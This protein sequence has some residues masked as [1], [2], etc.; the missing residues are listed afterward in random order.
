MMI[1]K[2]VNYIEIY[3]VFNYEVTCE[4]EAKR[5]NSGT[6]MKTFEES[7]KTATIHRIQQG[8]YGVSA[9]A[10]H[11]NA[12]LSIPYLALIDLILSWTSREINPIRH[13][14]LW[15]IIVNGD[16]QEEPTLTGYQS[17]P[18]APPAPKTT[19]KLVAKRNQERVKSILLLA[20]PDEYLLKF[21]NVPD[22]KSLWEA[23]KSRFGG[24]EESKKMQKNHISQLEVY[25]APVSKEDINKKFLRSL[26]PSWNQI[27][28]I[29][30]NKPD[31]DQTDINDLYNNLRTNEVST[32]N[33]D[34]FI[35]TAGGTS[36]VSSTPC[37]HFQ[38]IDEDGL[39]EL[40]LRWQVAMECKSRRNQGRRSYGDNGRSNAPTNESLLQA[41]MAQ[42]GLGGYDWSNDFEVE[43]VNYALM[44]ISSSTSSSSSDNEV[45]NYSKQCVKSFKT[46]Q[47]N[48]DSERE[49]HN[50]AR[51]EIQGYEIALGSLE[52]RI[53]RHEKNEL[54]WGEKYEFQNYELNQMSARDKT[55]LGY[56]TQL[57]EMC[58]N[59]ETDTEIS[60]KD[61]MSQDLTSWEPIDQAWEKHSHNHFCAPTTLDMEVLIKTCLMPLAI[62]TQNDSFAFVHE[63]KQEMHA[64][65]NP[66]RNSPKHVS[67]QSP[68]ESVGSNDMV[69]NYYLEEAKKK[70]QLHKDKA[71]NTKPSVQQS[72]RLPNTANGN[73]PKPRNFNQQPRNLPPSM[74]SR[75]S[76]RTVNTTEPPRNQKSFLKSKD[77]AFPT[78]KKCIYSANH[79]ECILKYLSK[80]NSCASTQKKHAQSH[81]TTKKY[82]PR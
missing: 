68:R 27:D 21:H 3:D 9:Q 79:D 16:L 53:L 64:D 73:K 41:L 12:F 8:R 49:K 78:C 13:H 11:K 50:R 81:K 17:G 24:N 71:L 51:L 32:A 10:H 66:S 20:I 59:S 63:L 58:I 43:P 60:L 26:P 40:D 52:S 39:E 6:K 67:F 2:T 56:G 61:L 7:T 31:I 4:E 36:Q 57:N 55:S 69:H 76:N 62:K 54:A 28:L 34:F 72:A 47:K 35:N 80:D 15:D 77:L 22:A 1:V 44:A 46:L 82:I 23:I 25:A 5:R 48:F 65:L 14:N 19:K 38:Q 74:S 37:A 18:S 30:R 42:D 70:A 29:I 45:Q 33:G 75:V